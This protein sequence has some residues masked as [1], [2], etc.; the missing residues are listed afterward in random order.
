MLVVFGSFNFEVIQKPR[1]IFEIMS[2]LKN[3]NMNGP[4]QN[5]S[6]KAM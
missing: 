1:K 6:W 2:L 5:R 3:V 4:F